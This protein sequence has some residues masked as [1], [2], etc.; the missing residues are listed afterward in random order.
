M[1]APSVDGTRIKILTTEG[2]HLT[3]E[4]ELDEYD[5]EVVAQLHG[6]ESRDISGVTGDWAVVCDRGT[7]YVQAAT[8]AEGIQYRAR[9]HDY[10]HGGRVTFPDTG[11]SGIAPADD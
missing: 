9:I 1:L 7:S 3:A 11:G 6:V 4:V 8:L 5:D 10:G 2:D